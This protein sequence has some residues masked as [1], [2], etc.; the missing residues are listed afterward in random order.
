MN[1]Y[2]RLCDDEDFVKQTYTN[3]LKKSTHAQL[4]CPS[5]CSVNAE[6]YLL[7]GV[8]TL[9]SVLIE[10]SLATVVLL[11]GEGKKFCS[12]RWGS[13]LPGFSYGVEKERKN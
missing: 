9:I 1:C 6:Q 7:F 12:R 3:I 10:H 2:S 4:P 8:K 5:V 13:W 11:E